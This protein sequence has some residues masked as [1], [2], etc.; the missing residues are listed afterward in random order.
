M[1]LQPSSVCR[2]GLDAGLGRRRRV[3]FAAFAAATLA[4]RHSGKPSSASS[5]SFAG[6]CK[7]PTVHK[8][9][10]AGLTL[11]VAPHATRSRDFSRAAAKYGVRSTTLDE[12]SPKKGSLPSRTLLL[13]LGILFLLQAGFS[14][15]GAAALSTVFAASSQI[16]PAMVT[17]LFVAGGTCACVSHAG[18]TPLDVVKTRQQ[19]EPMRYRC[20][21]TGR[22]LSIIQTGMRIAQEEGPQMLL[23]GFWATCL[24]YL[25]QGSFKFGFW[26]VLKIC[27]GY[28]EAVGW[29]RFFI[30]VVAAS[31]ADFFASVLLC[32]F[33]RARIK[34]VSD[35]SFALCP[36]RALI[37][38]VRE[39]GFYYG[40]F[41]RGL[42]ATMIKQQMYTIGKLTA[43]E[44]AMDAMSGL[45]AGSGLPRVCSALPS[46]LIAGF[47]AS[48]LSQ[49]GDT[50]QVCMSSRK[51]LNQQCP[52]DPSDPTKPLS[53]KETAAAL[54]FRG[55][56]QGWRARL[57]QMEVIVVTQLLIYDSIKAIAGL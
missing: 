52:L 47:V 57:L 29:A 51:P 27:M 35:P 12:A 38:M 28:D 10:A 53:L 1:V 41:G 40:C 8:S 3:V 39:E 37:R 4:T 15:D 34:L 22:P 43:F 45:L 25:V 23:Q 7:Q 19:C 9:F 49:P 2:P 5:T 48:V 21:E 26:E 31:G 13:M 55:L 18:A 20:R 46:A 44:V 56:F 33:E 50:L 30:L 36:V 42:A 17:K 6:P 54:G 11:D 32:P 24:G 14:T 16:D